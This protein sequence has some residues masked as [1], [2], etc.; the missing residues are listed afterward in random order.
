MPRFRPQTLAVPF[1]YLVVAGLLLP[2]RP[3]RALDEDLVQRS[4]YYASEL[5]DRYPADRFFILNFGV[6]TNL[7][8]DALSA[9]TGEENPDSYY[10]AVPLYD[11][12][13]F[14]GMNSVRA[15]T[16]LEK[17]VPSEE[18][19]TGRTLVFHRVLSKAWGITIFY[20]TFVDFMEAHRPNTKFTFYLIGTSFPSAIEWFPGSRWG[21]HGSILVRDR[22][23]SERMTLGQDRGNLASPFYASQSLPFTPKAVEEDGF[24]F[25]PNPGYAQ[26]GQEF[27]NGCCPRNG[28]S[29][30]RRRGCRSA[31][32]QP[33]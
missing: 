30:R 11:I 6:S 31:A 33:S 8:S 16:I 28:R 21:R 18:I 20:R 19:L 4:Y 3:A 17:L 29:W 2:A 25:Q 13:S 9:L 14:R 23:Y 1:L 5:M 24:V 7:I 10:R 22:D 12:D 15:A 26:F 27:A 32:G